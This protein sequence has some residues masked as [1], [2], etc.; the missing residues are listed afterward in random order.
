MRK[1]KFSAGGVALGAVTLL[2]VAAIC[3][4][5]TA[6]AT[7][8]AGI[9]SANVSVG[10][11]DAMWVS[12]SFKTPTGKHR[13]RIKTRG[14]SDVYV[15]SNKIA[16]GGHTGWHT[17]PGPSL[18]TVKSGTITAYNASDRK[19]R[20][21]VY[22]AGSGFID[23]GNGNLHLLRNEGTVEAETIAVQF[24]P[25]AGERRIDTPKPDNCPF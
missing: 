4:A 20:P 19:C 16:P 17:H 12:T 24:I 7:P 5:G 9:T 25:A 23:P 22:P 3:V 11:F 13:V 10:R 21:T 18:V 2:G 14:A 6:L 1:P 8:G 15:V